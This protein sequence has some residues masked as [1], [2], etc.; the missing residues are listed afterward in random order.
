VT[1]PPAVLKTTAYVGFRRKHDQP[2]PAASK[3]P[4]IANPMDEKKPPI[5]RITPK[6]IKRVTPV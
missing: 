4:K 1:S 2:P 5:A 3:T 6:N